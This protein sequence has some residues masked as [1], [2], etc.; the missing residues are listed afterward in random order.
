MRYYR[1]FLTLKV[2]LSNFHFSLH[3]TDN[4]AH[5]VFTSYHVNVVLHELLFWVHSR[6]YNI[7]WGLMAMHAE[8]VSSGIQV[9]GVT[10]LLTSFLSG[11]I[12]EDDAWHCRHWSTLA[13]SRLS[14]FSAS[15]LADLCQVRWQPTPS[16]NPNLQTKKSLFAQNV[17]K[18]NIMPLRLLMI[19]NTVVY[20]A[21]GIIYY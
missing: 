11:D 17:N 3:M 18:I 20:D 1:L 9:S 14:E 21:V 8:T 15:L 13:F 16:P 19:K 2:V 7:S 12:Y 5:L 10:G 4:P 6:V